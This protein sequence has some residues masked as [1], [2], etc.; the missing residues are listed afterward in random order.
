MGKRMEWAV[1]AVV[2]T[3]SLLGCNKSEPGPDANQ[4]GSGQLQEAED[5]GPSAEELVAQEKARVLRAS[6][7]QL[8]KLDA[9][10]KQWAGEVPT[11]NALAKAMLDQ[12]GSAFQ[13]ALGRAREALDSAGGASVDTW[14]EV[15][16]NLETAVGAAQSAYDAFLAHIRHQAQQEEQ[17]DAHPETD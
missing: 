2:L 6:E 13:D 16:P 10:F 9:Q 7:L 11:E 3:L 1:L 5:A 12:L 17:K 15:R 14:N 4:T 8:A